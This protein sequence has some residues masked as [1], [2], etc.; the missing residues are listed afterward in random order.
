MTDQKKLG[1][2]EQVLAAALALSGGDLASTFSAEDLLLQAWRGDP[3]AW[4]LRQHEKEHPDSERIYLAIER[5]SVKGGLVGLGLFEKVQ[6]RVYRLTPAGLAKASTIGPGDPKVREKADRVIEEEMHRM[7]GHPT[8]LAW[9]ETDEVPKKFRDAS[10]FWNIAAGTP[11]DVVQGRLQKIEATAAAALAILNAK[12]VHEVRKK[13]S[14]LYD[15]SD[16]VML[17]QFQAAM[18]YAFRRELRMMGAE[19]GD[20][21][22]PSGSDGPRPRVRP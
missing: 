5:A 9:S 22:P 1:L 11:A 19:I 13:G 6:P 8:Y 17:M 16:V 12:G 7:L 10:H 3:Y 14:H 20:E 4:G 2:R 18:K 21:A 15:R